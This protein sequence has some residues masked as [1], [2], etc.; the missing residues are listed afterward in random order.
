[1]RACSAILFTFALAA[2]PRMTH[3]DV[4]ESPPPRY[5]IPDPPCNDRLD[6]V[7]YRSCTP[8]GA[9]G[10]NLLE[11]YMFVDLGMNLRHFSQAPRT[12]VA[13]R[14]MSP[15][16]AAGNDQE[17]VT[18]DE[19]VGIGLSQVLYTALDFELGNLAAIDTSPSAAPDM[20]VA[21]L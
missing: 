1:M 13:S 5:L 10:Q 14:S 11:P 3:A 8:Y 21:T 4:D 6:V 12:G 16:S 7:G 15:V 9:W 19:R 20:M 18:F 2:A 17:A